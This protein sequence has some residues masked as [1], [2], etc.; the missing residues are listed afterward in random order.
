MTTS[1]NMSTITK[2]VET[3]LNND[4]NFE[5][6]TI[7]RGEK[8]NEDPANCPWIGIYRR[9]QKYDPRTLGR[10]VGHRSFEG[11]VYIIVQ[12]TSLKDGSECEDLLDEAV[13]KVVNAVLTDPQFRSNVDMTNG[14][15]IDYSYDST[16]DEEYESYFQTAFIELTMEGET[17]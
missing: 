1:K 4:Q 13:Q 14:L 9:S 7:C 8:V 2:A 15:V 17:S 6:Y 16:S 11:V 12:E 3:V 10:G 5:N